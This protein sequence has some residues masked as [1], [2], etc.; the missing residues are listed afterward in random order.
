MTIEHRSYLGGSVQSLGFKNEEGFDMTVGVI[1]GAGVYDFGKAERYE[2]I[3]IMSGEIIGMDGTRYSN[4]RLLKF[5]KGTDIKFR[6]EGPT[7]YL[8]IYDDRP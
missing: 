6:T 8:C 7:S 5:D 4:R 1:A 3:F 2:K